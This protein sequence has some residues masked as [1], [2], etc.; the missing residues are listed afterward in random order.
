MLTP[1]ICNSSI[2]FARV[3]HS[4]DSPFMITGGWEARL[5]RRDSLRY[6]AL[7][8]SRLVM[9]ECHTIW[10]VFIDCLGV[11]HGSFRRLTDRRNWKK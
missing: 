6:V 5:D 3:V 10:A 2:R 9:N 8:S 1:G 7:R 11:G 4:L